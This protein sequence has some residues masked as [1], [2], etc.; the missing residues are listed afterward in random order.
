MWELGLIFIV[1]GIVLFLIEAATPGF[2]IAIPATIMIVLG[3]I[4]LVWPEFLVSFWSPIVAVIIGVPATV[5]TIL[6]YQRL[7]PPEAPAT[8]V[9]ESLKGKVGI[10]IT[11]IEPTTIRGKVK[12][13]NQTW[14]ATADHKIPVATKV[15]V[16]NSKGVHVIVEELEIYEKKK[17]ED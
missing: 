16:I 15:K 11:E 17:K 6:L 2:F 10:V 4:E 7:A 3:C 1:I 5:A 12:I 9:A 13:E 8:T 14:S